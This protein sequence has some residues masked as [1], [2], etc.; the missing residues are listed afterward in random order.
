MK[1]K[2]KSKNLAIIVLP[3]ALVAGYFLWIQPKYN[4]P[5]ANNASQNNTVNPAIAVTTVN[6]TKQKIE[7][8]IELPG[9]VN[10][11]KISGVRPQVDGVIKEVKFVEGSFVKQ[12]QQLYEID[13]AIYKAAY[14]SAVSAL[15]AAKAKRDRYQNLIAQDAISKQEFDDV[16]AAFA[17]AQSDLSKAKK[18]LDYTSVLAPISGYIGKSNFTQGALVTANQADALTTITQLDPIYVDME[19]SSKD[20]IA[21]GNHEELSVSLVTEDPNY[22]NVGKLKFSEVFADESTDSVRLRAIFSNKDKKLLPGMFVSAKLHLKPFDAI[23]IPQR[24]ANRAPN[25]SLVVW[26]VG[27]DNTVKSQ[28]I[29]AEKIY[30]DSWIVEEG[31]NEGDKIIYEGFQKLAEGVKV[32]PTPLVTQEIK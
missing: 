17:S 24:A 14:N 21:L 5:N 19:Q 32:N 12:G 29:K 9:R 16:N 23:T 13:S 11:Q 1:I 8:F 25:G 26:V 31:L 2:N 4:Q 10:G 20:A 15:K 22:H 3:A 7:L 18:N 6:A 27:Q 28:I 30:Q